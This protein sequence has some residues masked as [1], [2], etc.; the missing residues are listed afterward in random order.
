MNCVR[1]VV[2]RKSI[3]QRKGGVR[4]RDGGERTGGIGARQNCEGNGGLTGIMGLT[5]KGCDFVYSVVGHI[6]TFHLSEK[7]E[8][9]PS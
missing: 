2:H 1:K 4:G 5:T 6:S 9:S 3:R 8:R 7:A